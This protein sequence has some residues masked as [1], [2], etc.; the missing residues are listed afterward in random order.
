MTQSAQSDTPNTVH[1]A[2]VAKIRTMI[3]GFDDI[4]HG[5]LP[6]GRT[7]LVSG[8]SGTGKTLMAVQFLYN[9]IVYFDEPGV[10]VTFEESPRGHRQKCL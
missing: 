2:G 4:S 7:T 1:P 5:G 9:G 3:E 10:F 8:T 6:V